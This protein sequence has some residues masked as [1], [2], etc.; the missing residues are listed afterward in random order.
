MKNQQAEH[1]ETTTSKITHL[2]RCERI[3]FP[4]AFPL[5]FHSQLKKM[6]QTKQRRIRNVAICW[7]GEPDHRCLVS[8]PDNSA[9]Y[10]KL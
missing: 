5:I 8:T 6:W 10:R 7:A 3:N 9:F 2:H 4:A 1:N